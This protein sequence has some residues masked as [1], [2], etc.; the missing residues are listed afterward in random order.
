MGACLSG[1]SS[2]SMTDM[3]NQKPHPIFDTDKSIFYTDDRKRLWKVHTEPNEYETI[4][5]YNNNIAI[6]KLSPHCNLLRP[7]SVIR[8]NKN[9]ILLCMSLGK[10]DLFNIIEQPFD[11]KFIKKE[12]SALSLAILY[13]HTNGIAHRDIKPENVVL[14]RGRLCLIDFDFAG[15]VSHKIHCGTP[16]F[17]CPMDVT[18]TWDCCA[19]VFSRRCDVYSFGKLIMAIFWQASTHGMIEHSRF[20]FAAFHADFVK[21]ITHPFTGSWGKWASI[22]LHCISKVPPCSIPLYF[23]DSVDKLVAT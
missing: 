8:R 7:T 6:S 18:S 9:T 22:A 4:C 21:D 10:T 19:T 13:L 17:K 1:A 14:Y 11:W 15:P 2:T 16:F 12:L 23:D 5:I 20:I 3:Q